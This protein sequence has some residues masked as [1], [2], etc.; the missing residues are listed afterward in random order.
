[1]CGEM[2]ERKS[3]KQSRVLPTTESRAWEEAFFPEKENPLK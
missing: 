2:E 3:S 1:M